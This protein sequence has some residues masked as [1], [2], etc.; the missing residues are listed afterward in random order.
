M[1]HTVYANEIRYMVRM[2]E[3]KEEKYFL[4]KPETRQCKIK[5][6][7]W[8]N[9]IL[10]KIKVT[11]LPINCNISTTGHKLQG[12]TLDH[13][14]VNS[15]AYGCTH[16]VY[17]VLS[18]VRRLKDLILNTK[19]DIHRNYKAKSDLIRW[20]QDIKMIIEQRTFK[21]RGMTDYHQYLEEEERYQI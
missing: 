1:V 5:M 18:R 16:W 8:K 12:K 13:L 7:M 10:D 14:V 17:F 3:D 4:I 19:L 20:E 21:D 2:H 15:F 11:H 6:R 9:M